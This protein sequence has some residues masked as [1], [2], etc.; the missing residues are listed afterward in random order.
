MKISDGKAF[1]EIKN[2]VLNMSNSGSN[3]EMDN[4]NTNT[5][6]DNNITNKNNNY[7]SEKPVDKSQ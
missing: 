4:G 6:V 1:N 3:N 7:N 5:Y 2:E